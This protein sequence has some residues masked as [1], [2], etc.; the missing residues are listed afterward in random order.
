MLDV[1]SGWGGINRA[2]RGLTAI[3]VRACIYDTCIRTYIYI[4]TIRSAGLSLLAVRPNH[5]CGPRCFD[6]EAVL[7]LERSV[8]VRHLY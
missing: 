1:F 6:N 4:Y 5:E 2:F 7:Q 3:Y 8:R